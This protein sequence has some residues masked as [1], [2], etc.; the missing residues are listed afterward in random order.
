VPA[1]AA[2]RIGDGDA[3]ARRGSEV[4]VIES[5]AE[6]GDQRQASGAVEA[7][8]GLIG[9]LDYGHIDQPLIMMGRSMGG[10][11]AMDFALTNPSRALIMVDAGRQTGNWTRQST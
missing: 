5:C 3:M 4:D 10:G 9:L 6:L 2:R 11:L 7:A 8:S 1:H